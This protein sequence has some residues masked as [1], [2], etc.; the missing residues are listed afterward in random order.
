MEIW[1]QYPCIYEIN[2]LVWL[3]ELSQIQ[4][5]VVTLMDVPSEQWDAIAAL[6]IDAVWFMGVWERSPAGIRLSMED[7]NRLDSFKQALPDFTTEDNVGSAY[8]VRRYVVDERLGGPA[9]LMEAKRQLWQRG[10]RLILDYVPNHVAPDHPWVLDHLEY[11]IHGT[12]EEL[13]KTPAN[14]ITVNNHILA[15]G[16]KEWPD[17]IQ[18]NA[19]NQQMRKATANTIK[20]IA[21]QCDGIRCDMAM[22]MMNSVFE[23]KWEHLA[24]TKPSQEYWPDIISQVKT[25]YPDTLFIAE[26]Y[27]EHKWELQQQ[28]FDYCYDK[29]R[30]Y[31]RLKEGNVDGVRLHLKYA[32]LSY[33]SKLIR[34]IENHDESRAVKVFSPPERER[35]AAIVAMSLPGA[36]LIHEG[37]LEGRQVKIPVFLRR[38]PP[39]PVD[40]NL[41]AFYVKLLQE[42]HNGIFHDGEWM[43]C[44]QSG[45]PDNTSYHN[46]LS[47]CWHNERERRLI[48]VNMSSNSSQGRV[49]VP[50]DEIGGHFW[51][52]KD[53]FSGQIFDRDGDEMLNPGL[54]VALEGW[55]VHF[56]EVTSI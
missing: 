48:A 36:K 10:I 21:S 29:D 40:S 25:N 34:F 47:W 13:L 26:V 20:E 3:Y 52:L 30:L 17:V 12:E 50:W 44:E 23:G 38:R 15:C 31:Q 16:N 4:G 39:E 37:Q 41:R 27:G 42:I 54:Y 8:C 5:R 32:S 9:G 46:L 53:V 35:G 18:L 49:H 28:G 22:L 19:F 1:P 14:F 51:R 24:G 43:L 33:Q 6:K 55:A 11:F 2:T 7:A 45:W 56:F